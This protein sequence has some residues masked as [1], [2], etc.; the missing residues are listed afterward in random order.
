MR[1]AKR[2][3]ERFREKLRRLTKRTRPGKLE[4]I[5]S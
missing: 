3:L 1:V 5:W 4:D 2:S